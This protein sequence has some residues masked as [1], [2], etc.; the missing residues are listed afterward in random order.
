MVSIVVVAVS[1][2]P[3]SYSRVTLF[4]LLLFDFQL[5]REEIDFVRRVVCVLNITGRPM[6]YAYLPFTPSLNNFYVRGVGV[7]SMGG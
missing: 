3:F 1:S 6:I 2:F 5:K 7:A 4:L